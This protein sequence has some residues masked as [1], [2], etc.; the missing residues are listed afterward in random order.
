MLRRL[1]TNEEGSLDKANAFVFNLKEML[2]II[3]VG[4]EKVL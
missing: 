4:S 2:C 3:L 1:R